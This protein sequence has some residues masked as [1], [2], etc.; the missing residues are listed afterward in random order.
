ATLAPGVNAGDIIWR[1]T[2]DDHNALLEASQSKLWKETIDTLFAPSGLLATQEH[3]EYSDDRT[4]GRPLRRG[5]YRVA[6]FHAS[7][8]PAPGRLAQFA[9]ETASMPHY[10][11]TIRRWNLAQPAKQRG[12]RP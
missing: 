1:V 4:G 6:L 10:I 12:T 2:F 11:N 7:E 9:S 5:I 8:N 3:V